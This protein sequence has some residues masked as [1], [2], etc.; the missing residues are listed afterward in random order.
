[1]T[2]AAIAAAGCGG[3]DDSGGDGRERPLA[4]TSEAQACPPETREALEAAQELMAAED[5]DGTFARLR[6]LRD[7]PEVAERLD[8]HRRAAA[9]RMLEIAR[10]RRREARD[11]DLSPQAAVAIAT[12]SIRYHPTEE[13][14]RF[15]RRVKRELAD[16]K[17]THGPEPDDD[18][19]PPPGAGEGGPP[20][21]DR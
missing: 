2:G 16:F 4:G 14:E 9:R 8:G 10:A 11:R 13:A 7:C 15:L 19:G 21:K 12:T 5:F 6:P 17:R 20:D 1:M 3:D 18:D